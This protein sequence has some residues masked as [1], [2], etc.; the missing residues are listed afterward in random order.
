MLSHRCKS[1]TI[2]QGYKGL[3]ILC[4]FQLTSWT[5]SISLSDL[6]CAR[7]ALNTEERGPVLYELHFKF[8]A[9]NITVNLSIEIK[10]TMSGVQYT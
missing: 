9:Q 7:R 6:F 10:N 1:L 5:E 8:L 3:P 2:K 4:F